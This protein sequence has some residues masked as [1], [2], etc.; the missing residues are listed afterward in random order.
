MMGMQKRAKLTSHQRVLLGQL[1]GG[2][3]GGTAASYAPLAFGASP[4][5][6]YTLAGSLGGMGAGAALAAKK[7]KKKRKVAKE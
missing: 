7:R 3:V 1:L 4:H 2:L 6:G 5:I